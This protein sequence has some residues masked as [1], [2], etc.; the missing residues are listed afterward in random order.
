M[1][2]GYVR[3]KTLWIV[4]LWE[5]NQ[6][7]DAVM[8]QGYSYHLIVDYFPITPHHEAFYSFYNDKF[9]NADH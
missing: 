9:V 4:L 3:S 5:N 7:Q 1:T 6:P 2:G 8:N